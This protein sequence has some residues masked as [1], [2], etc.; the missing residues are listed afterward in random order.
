MPEGLRVA[1]SE[2]LSAEPEGHLWESPARWLGRGRFSGMCRSGGGVLFLHHAPSRH[3]FINCVEMRRRRGYR[4]SS[5]TSL[6][7]LD[8]EFASASE[9]W[10]SACSSLA[11]A[12][13]TDHSGCR[14]RVNTSAGG[15]ADVPHTREKFARSHRQPPRAATRMRAPSTSESNSKATSSSSGLPASGGP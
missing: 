8:A 5:A 11:T 2:G 1:L 7:C 15:S 13:A 9:A 14:T 10:A 6:G 4:C 3:R 12:K